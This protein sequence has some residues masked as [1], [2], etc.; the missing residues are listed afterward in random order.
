MSD[1]LRKKN[2]AGNRL[3]QAACLGL[4]VLAL[5]SAFSCGRAPREGQAL[6]TPFPVTDRGGNSREYRLFLPDVADAPLPL[7]V[8]FHGVISPGFKTIPGLKEYTGSPIE[9][10]GWIPFCRARRIVLLV[11]EALYEYVFLK[12]TSKGWPTEKELDG[13]EKIIDTVVEKFP[14][15]RTR[16]Y[17]AGISAGAVFSHFLANHRPSFYSA[18]VSHS[19]AYVSERNEVLDPAVRGPQFGVVFCYNIGDYRQ[20]IGFC[21]KSEEIYRGAG[22][23]TILLPDLPPRGHAW[24][25][26]NNA[27]FWKLLQRLGRREETPKT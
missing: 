4:L 1:R 25:A 23:R 19:Q 7:L 12:Q 9:E 5:S 14:I 27:R 8:Y 10:T 24:S 2:S 22:Y 26:P 20:L 18:I 16:I 15:D 21:V 11:P 17:L 13:V 6:K 3:L